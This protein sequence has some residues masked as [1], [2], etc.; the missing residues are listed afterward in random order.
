LA[1]PALEHYFPNQ[2][3]PYLLVDGYANTNM[4]SMIVRSHIFPEEKDSKIRPL[5]LFVN[6]L[7]NKILCTHTCNLLINTI[8][9]WKLVSAFD[10]SVAP[11][12]RTTGL[13]YEL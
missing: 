5:C 6:P 2:R 8:Q 1:A 9:L 11:L 13:T 3:Y 10:L 4:Q 12:L 7:H